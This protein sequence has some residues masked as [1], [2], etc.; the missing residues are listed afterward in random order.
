M[1]IGSSIFRLIVFVLSNIV[2]VFE[3]R[4]FGLE[5]DFY[6]LVLFVMCCFKIFI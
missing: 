3:I 4:V 5:G 6:F 2:R 1:V